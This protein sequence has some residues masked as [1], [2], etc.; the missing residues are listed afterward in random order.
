M[1]GR[2][3]VLFRVGSGNA[4][5]RWNLCFPVKHPGKLLIQYPNKE[6]A[7]GRSGPS[8]RSGRM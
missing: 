2:K 8:C 7:P 6:A 3:S 5:L 4:V 1:I